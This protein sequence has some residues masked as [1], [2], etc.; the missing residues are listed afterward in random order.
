MPEESNPMIRLWKC[1]CEYHFD[2][3]RFLP[4]NDH[5]ELLIGKGFV[6]GKVKMNDSLKDRFSRLVE[7][8][9]GLDGYDIGC[10]ECRNMF[11]DGY[12]ALCD[13]LFIW[14][15]RRADLDR[16]GGITEWASKKPA[17]QNWVDVDWSDDKIEAFLD[18]AEQTE[19]ADDT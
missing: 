13:L 3:D 6:P 11:P 17:G 1:G 9:K 2:G 16:D 15:G 7:R 12:R 10:K 14:N 8:F 5:L 4:C 19:V 18:W